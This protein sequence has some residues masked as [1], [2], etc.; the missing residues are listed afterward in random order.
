MSY[1]ARPKCRP[2]SRGISAYEYHIRR[3]QLKTLPPKKKR[4]QINK[5]RVV[6]IPKRRRVGDDGFWDNLTLVEV[7][8]AAA[9]L[10]A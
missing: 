10:T 4:I 5:L 7:W 3:Q 8:G 2:D 6:V 9:G 1:P